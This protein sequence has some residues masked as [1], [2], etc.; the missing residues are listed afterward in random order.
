MWVSP[1]WVVG[2]PRLHVA[3]DDHL[4]VLCLDGVVELYITFGIVVALVAIILWMEIVVFVANL[5][6]SQV[7]GL[8]VSV[9]RTLGAPFG[10]NIAITI[11]NGIHRLIDIFLYLVVGD[12]PSVTY[13]HIYYEERFGT[14][15]LGQLQQFMESQSVA[16]VVVPV[17]VTVSWS[18]F[19]RTNGFLP[20]KAVGFTIS[21]FSLYKASSGESYKGGVYCF[22]LLRQVDATAVGPI[23]IGRWEQANHINDE[24]PFL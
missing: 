10:R 19:D 11:L 3:D 13:T 16:Y 1:R 2:T 4:R 6:E 7:E 17:Y 20:F 22:Q 5:N 24:V 15:I 12:H 21:V 9:C 8:G 18:F 14:E 23:F